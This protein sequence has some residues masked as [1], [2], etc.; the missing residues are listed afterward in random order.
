[1]SHSSAESARSAASRIQDNPA[2]QFA[3]RT[4][5]A[6]NGLLHLLIGGIALSVAFGSGGDA[7]QSGALQGLASTPGGVFVLW[8]VAIGLIAL[9]L[10]QVLETVLVRGTDKEAWVDRAKQGG[11]AIAYLAIGISA[12][13]V[14]LGSGG[15]S[16]G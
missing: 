10:F 8:V 9:G 3:A 7:D 1:M 4:G 5:F 13:S 16:S 14:A 6:V 11:K 12:A 15:D 2:F